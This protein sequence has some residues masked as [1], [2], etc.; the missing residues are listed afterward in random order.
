MFFAFLKNLMQPFRSARGGA[1]PG[2][3]AGSLRLP[4]GGRQPY[5]DWKIFD[6][7]AGPQ[8]DFV[9]HYADLR[10]FADESVT[11]IYA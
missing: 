3:G 6:V 9:G 11:E 4:I 5:P 8:V 10:Q 2:Q 7:E 1:A